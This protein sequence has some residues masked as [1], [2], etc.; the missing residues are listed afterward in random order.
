MSEKRIA[1]GVLA[2]VDS[3]KTTLIEAILYNMGKIR[4]LGRVDH[5]DSFLDTDEIERERGITVF[6]K[7]AVFQKGNTS[8]TLLD[9]PGHADFGAEA[10]RTVKILDYAILVISASDG[11]QSHT[12][13]LWKMLETY[14][15][16]VFIFVNKMDLHYGT[17]DDI[18]NEL[19][20]QFSDGCTDFGSP[21]DKDT[22][23][24]MSLCD[25][26]IMDA[27]L[28]GNIDDITL[29]KAIRRRNIF[30]VCF[31]SALKNEGVD[32]LT[33]II[34]TYS[35]DDEEKKDFGARVFKISEDKN[36]RLTHIKVTG[37]VLNVKDSISG[38][39]LSGKAFSQKVNEIRIYSGDKYVSVPSAPQGTVCCVT[40]L[41]MT[42]SG[43]GLGTEKDL[44]IEVL[45]PVFSYNVIVKDNTNTSIVI[46]AF[47]K[48]CQEETKLNASWNSSL[49]AITVRLM[50]KMQTDVIKRVMK[51][52]FGIEIDFEEGGIVYK[53]TI[54]DTVEGVG[55]YEPLRH[56]AEVHL[57]LKPAKRGSGVTFSSKCREDELDLN[58]QRLILTHLAEKTHLGVLTGSPIT[59]IEIVLASGRAHLKHTDGGDFRQ[60]TY[61]AVRHGLRSAKSI[62]LEPWYNF[63][64]DVPEDCTGKVLNDLSQMGAVF[65][66]PEINDG[67]SRT[68]GSA[69]V[70]K[71]QS[72]HSS[73]VAFTHG[74][75]SIS[76]SLKGY[77]PCENPQE[78]IDKK[79][80]NPDADTENTADSVFCSHGAAFNVNWQDVTKHMH[81]ESVLKEKNEDT[82][83]VKKS[84]KVFDAAR[85]SD[86]ELDKIF[87]MTFGKPKEKPMKV[88][89]ATGAITYKSKEK[90]LNYKE[91][92]ILVDGYN[93]IF[94]WEELKN[95]AKENID[96][97]R[98]SLITKLINY[99]AVKGCRLAVVF[100]AY[101]VK[102]NLGDVEKV[103]GIDIVYT[104]E[105]ETADT[106]IEWLSHTLSSEYLVRVATSDNLEQMIIVGAGAL[107]VSA[108]QFEKEVADVEKAIRDFL[109]N[110]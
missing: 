92:Y 60:A 82:L 39:D 107:R 56:Y 106:Y 49:N 58:W 42:Y 65:S 59:D 76:L 21:F 96:L 32:T 31:G 46:D 50:G 15:V 102:G 74:M 22:K 16:P 94:A 66:Q 47:K 54:E 41:D 83:T 110:Q 26:G 89:N 43:M 80:Y 23:E 101:K 45:E 35:A 25:E 6:S 88:K 98:N 61:R 40:G 11:I 1:L 10:E 29:A 53:E 73:L 93:I 9:T 38:T 71:L 63:V 75:G 97:A 103:N 55:H 87:E 52:R 77:Q 34:D 104:K 72:Y 81:L 4:K 24:E 18:L 7:Q 64:I 84:D 12:K 44:S 57:L 68:K 20:L 36:V 17:K 30:P 90:K 51:D 27:F 86:A 100:D 33:E 62:L 69:P 67:F 109:N 8:I 5:K 70:E 91:E 99:K 19:K 14:K 48:L 28:N 95:A 13:T 3:G 85:V 108:K 105:A 2:H 78:I 79:A 37:G